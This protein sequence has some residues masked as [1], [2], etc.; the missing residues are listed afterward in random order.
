MWPESLKPLYEQ[1]ASAAPEGVLASQGQWAERLAE[2]V[3]GATW[4]NA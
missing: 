4:M 3:R 1:A 2:W